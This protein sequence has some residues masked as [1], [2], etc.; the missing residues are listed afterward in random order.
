MAEP[1]YGV[2]SLIYRAKS[3]SLG[4]SHLC[5]RRS[6]VA[7]ARRRYTTE[8][9]TAM[10]LSDLVRARVRRAAV[11][12]SNSTHTHTPT[13]LRACF[14]GKLRR[15]PD[16]WHCRHAKPANT[17][18]HSTH[19]VTPWPP[20]AQMCASCSRPTTGRM[21]SRTACRSRSAPPSCTEVRA[22]PASGT[23]HRPRRA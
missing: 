9:P 10:V 1:N 18:H 23:T 21:R 5:S 4:L 7:A 8:R 15:G 14:V 19:V 2:S 3:T 17:P 12:S 13:C 6:L 22:A 20:S 16:V 11:A